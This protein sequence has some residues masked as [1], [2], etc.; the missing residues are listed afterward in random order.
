MQSGVLG[1]VKGSACKVWT[2]PGGRAVYKAL[3]QNAGPE[4]SGGVPFLIS[5]FCF[6]A[7]LVQGA[8]AD[9]R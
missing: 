3:F 9:T 4:S 1:A 2:C 7:V 6:A 5:L 8:D